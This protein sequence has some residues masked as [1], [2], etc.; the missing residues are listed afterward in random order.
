M[1][2]Q[3]GEL[4]HADSSILREKQQGKNDSNSVSQGWVTDRLWAGVLSIMSSNYCFPQ[5]NI[6]CIMISTTRACHI[7]ALGKHKS[8]LTRFWSVQLLNL[9]PAL[10]VK[11]VL[12]QFVIWWCLRRRNWL[13]EEGRLFEKRAAIALKNPRRRKPIFAVHN[14]STSRNHTARISKSQE[15]LSQ[16]IKTPQGVYFY[17]HPSMEII[18]WYGHPEAVLQ[19]Y[20]A[21]TH[22]DLQSTM[23]QS[24][25]LLTA[26]GLFWVS[27]KGNL[28]DLQSLS[29]LSIA[30]HPREGKFRVLEAS[31]EK[32]QYH[33]SRFDYHAPIQDCKRRCVTRS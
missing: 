14:Q 11:I 20:L 12:R 6:S 23:P 21:S 26:L 4:R 18:C 3:D 22:K 29:R 13:G 10:Y 28:E 9:I 1:R 24:S 5:S 17:G 32:C 30:R 27:M 8:M 25:N 19:R 16:S 2:V 15:I 7:R 33:A 31:W